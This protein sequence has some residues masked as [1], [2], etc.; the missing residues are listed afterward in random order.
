[1]YNPTKIDELM[2]FF[3][4]QQVIQLTYAHNLRIWRSRNEVLHSS[5]DPQLADIRSTESAEV[6]HIHGDPDGLCQAD[7]HM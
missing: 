7:R 5:T 1:M 6:R 4:M 2:G 3:R